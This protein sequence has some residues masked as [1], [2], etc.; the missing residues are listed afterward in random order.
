MAG[1][2]VV[3]GTTGATTFVFL[4]GLDWVTDRRAA[5]EQLVWLLP[6][7]G[8]M[9]GIAYRQGKGPFVYRFEAP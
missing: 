8:L 4:R 7:V 1:A 3:G 5:H 6:L 9:I 2:I